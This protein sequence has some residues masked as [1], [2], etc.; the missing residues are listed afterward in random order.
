[1]TDICFDAGFVFDVPP[2]CTEHTP[3][4]VD[5]EIVSPWIELIER[6]ED[7]PAFLSAESLKAKQAGRRFH[8]DLIVQRHI[9]FSPSYSGYLPFALASTV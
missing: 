4:P 8:P 3:H 1:M 2:E 5:A 9:E 7:D 6:L